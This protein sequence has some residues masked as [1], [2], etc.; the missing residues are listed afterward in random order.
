V[1]WE[2]TEEISQPIFDACY[3]GEEKGSNLFKFIRLHYKKKNIKLM[4]EKKE[5][6]KKFDLK[7]YAA[8]KETSKAMGLNSEV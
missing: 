8:I 3:F 5:K 1:V 6:S 7:I 4:R 2:K